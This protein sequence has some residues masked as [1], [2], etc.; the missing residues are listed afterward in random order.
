M[1]TVKVYFEDGNTITTSINANLKEAT[2]YYLG[3]S[4][5]FGDSEECPQD[6]MV[7]AVKVEI[8]KKFKF[9]FVGRHVGAIGKTR[10]INHTVEAFN[11]A[12]AFAELYTKFEHITTVV[13]NGKL[14]SF[15]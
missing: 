2:K 10:V 13:L 11:E 1:N 12:Q 5:Q 4:F 6:K 7:K 14:L 9:S 15:R 3:K 8:L